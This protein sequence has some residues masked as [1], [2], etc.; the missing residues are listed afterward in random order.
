MDAMDAY[1]NKFGEM[2]CLYYARPGKNMVNKM[3]ARINRALKEN[4]KIP[5]EDPIYNQYPPDVLI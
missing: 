2:F 1:E 4:K 5:M 3:V